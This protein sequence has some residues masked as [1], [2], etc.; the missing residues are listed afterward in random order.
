MLRRILEYLIYRFPETMRS[1]E[2]RTEAWKNAK[3]DYDAR[4]QLEDEKDKY[5]KLY[6]EE[7]EKRE[8]LEQLFKK[9]EA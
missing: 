8:T 2:H 6:I 3:E 4:L 1:D 7:K 9:F 5:K